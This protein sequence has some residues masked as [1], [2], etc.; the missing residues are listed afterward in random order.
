MTRVPASVI[1]WLQAIRNARHYIL[2]ENAYFIPDRGI[3]RALY[4]AVKRGVSVAVVIPKDSDI[5]IIALATRAMYGELLIGGV[6]VTVGDEVLDT[7]VRARLASM[8]VAL[9]N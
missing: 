5:K 6:R 9:S 2:I 1:T 8:Q 3:R 4:R 7:S